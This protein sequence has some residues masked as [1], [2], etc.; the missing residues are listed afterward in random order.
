MSFILRC[1]RQ[2]ADLL[3]IGEVTVT[4]E[5]HMRAE[6]ESAGASRA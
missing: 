1:I 3:L 5:A 6:G 4:I 2:R